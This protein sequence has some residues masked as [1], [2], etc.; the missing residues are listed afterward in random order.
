MFD[1]N[2]DI[3]RGVTVNYL[4]T[5]FTLK[6]RLMQKALNG[7]DNNWVFHNLLTTHFD[8]NNVPVLEWSKEKIINIPERPGDFKVIQKDAEKMGYFE[9]K[10]Y[11][12]K[13]QAEGY[14]V[15]AIPCRFT[16]KNSFSLVIIILIFIGVS[17][18]LCSERSGGIMQSLGIGI[19]IGFSYFFVH[20]F[21]RLWAD[22]GIIL[23]VHN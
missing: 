7:R 3:L 21:V 16:R 1:V 15:T 9:L 23:P 19:F 13:I 2:K 17:F 12:K 11:I 5:D 10:K 22:S 4:N 14:D 18:S 8:K 20:A 6:M